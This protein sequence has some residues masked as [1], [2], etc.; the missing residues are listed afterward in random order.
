MSNP[1]KSGLNPNFRPGSPSSLGKK[2][3]KKKRRTDSDDDDSDSE[4]ISEQERERRE[5]L[6]AL[7]ASTKVHGTDKDILMNSFYFFLF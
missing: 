2:G 6:A 3:R 4:V 1:R 5:Y 7:H